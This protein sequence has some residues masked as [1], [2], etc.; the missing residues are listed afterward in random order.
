M[1]T[2]DEEMM[3]RALREAADDFAISD[4]AMESILDEARDSGA[5]TNRRG[6]ARSSSAMVELDRHC[7]LSLRAWWCWPSPCH[8]SIPKA[9][10]ARIELSLML[11]RGYAE[12]CEDCRP[13]S[14]RRDDHGNW[15]YHWRE[16]SGN[17]VANVDGTIRKGSKSSSNAS[18]VDSSLRVE[19]V[20]TIHLTVGGTHFQSTLTQLTDFATT[21]VDLSPARS[22]TWARKPLIPIPPAP[23]SCRF[24]SAISRC[25]STK[26][27]TPAWRRRS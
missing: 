5:R 15:F 1:T 11:R 26:C 17:F 12:Q 18:T 20:G 3:K 14:V 22:R 4:T 27:D 8:S 21:T 2:F 7:W 19:E 9:A 16:C 10:R 6:S 23:S 24:P 13:R 25:S